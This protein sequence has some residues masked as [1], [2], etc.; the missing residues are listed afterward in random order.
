LAGLLLAL[1]A[2]AAQVSPAAPS[3]R[4]QRFRFHHITVEQGLSNSWVFCTLKDY[5]GFQWI[6]TL[7]GL[8]RYDGRAFAHYHHVVGQ[9]HSLASSEIWS[10][11]EDSQHRLWVGAK[12]LNLYDREKD[13]FDVHPFPRPWNVTGEPAMRAIREDR[14]GRLWVATEAEGLLRSEPEKGAWKRY[15]HDPRQAPEA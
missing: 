12:G 11:L 10:L 14:A 13:R 7:D 2:Q 8:D 4:R 15:R 6:G 1:G 5:R 3:T 9:P